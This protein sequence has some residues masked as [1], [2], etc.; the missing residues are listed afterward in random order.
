MV[1]GYKEV[2]VS[3]IYHTIQVPPS[4]PLKIIRYK[5]QEP[6]LPSKKIAEEA[7]YQQS[8]R[9]EAERRAEAKRI[10]EEHDQREEEQRRLEDR[11][12]LKVTTEAQIPL[13]I[14]QATEPAV[15]ATKLSPMTSSLFEVSTSQE[16]TT[17]SAP[18]TFLPTP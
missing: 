18:E 9:E 14:T 7:E 4:D 3:I 13:E 2:L 12:Q 10:R 17:Q 8:L 11:K 6:D 5:R 16:T 1:S 15:S